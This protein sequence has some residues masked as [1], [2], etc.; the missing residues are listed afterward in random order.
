MRSDNYAPVGHAGARET[1]VASG[2]RFK[3]G[4][5]WRAFLKS[6]DESRVQQA[7]ASLQQ[8]LDTSHL[9]GMRILDVGCGSGLFSL[10]ARRL[11]AT[12]HSFD[13]DPDAVAA[14]EELKRRFAP[15]DALWTIE[16]GSA[17]DRRYLDGLGQFDLVYAFGVLHHTGAMWEA[18]ENMAPLVKP[19]GKLFVSIY[20][21]QGKPS[22]RWWWIKRTYNRLPPPLR[23]LVLWMSALW[24]WWRPM[25]KD[26]LLLH[27]FRTWRG[28]LHQRGM[29]PWHDLVDWVG[30]FPFE[31]AKPEQVFD[32][33][34]RRGF[35]L[36]RLVTRG[37]SF[38]CN[39]FL[40]R[41]CE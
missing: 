8:M 25:L 6:V 4:A 14:A 26:F 21:D 40:L 10:A 15:G 37:G 11:G 1:D 24:L 12:V 28:Y 9:H 35:S 2:L 29:S 22:Q 17:L 38:G 19:G 33:Y 16:T 27:P 18:L 23:F 13:F 3:F 5:N 36:E 7:E 32:F 20:N 39:Q 30:G 31:V 41:K 34:R